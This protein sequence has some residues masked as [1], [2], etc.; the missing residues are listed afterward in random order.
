M[1]FLRF[2]LRLPLLV[3]RGIYWIVS[4]IVGDVSWSAPRWMRATGSGLAYTGRGMRAHPGRSS[5]IVIA[6]AA[7]IG[8]GGWGY[9]W[10]ENRPRSVEEVPVAATVSGPP[11]KIGRASCRERV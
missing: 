7:L 4:K 10:Y 3:L 9:H 6:L 2:L 11:V 1:D 8:G 5:A